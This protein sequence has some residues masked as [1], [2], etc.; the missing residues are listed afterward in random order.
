MDLYQIN[1]VLMVA[2][3]KNFSHAAQEM[4]I[5]TSSLS[6]QIK[7]LEAELRVELFLRTTRS[8]HLTLAEKEF[9]AE[10]LKV[11]SAVDHVHDSMQ[12]YV[13]G[14]SGQ[15][16]LGSLP[17]IKAF[18][19]VNLLGA[20]QKQYPHVDLQL[21]E[22]ECLELYPK[23]QRG[24]IDVAFLS[25]FEKHRAD[26]LSVEG[27]PVFEDEVVMVV[28]KSHPFAGRPYISLREI[29]REKLI[30]PSKNS[31]LYQDITDAC[32]AAG[33]EPRF[34]YSS[35]YVD[36]ALGLVA[37]GL[38]V[39]LFSSCTVLNTLWKNVELVRIQPKIHRVISLVYLKKNK[40]S[41]VV[42]NFI[43]FFQQGGLQGKLPNNVV[44]LVR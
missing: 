40:N 10:A 28:N 17:A 39:T 25:A 35:Q 1:C 3:Y 37:E 8:V 21:Q 38:G 2:K 31:G 4:S 36:T 24:E 6:Q 18:G 14:E 15:I 32:R 34:S 43:K 42:A 5:T 23:L 29:A 16:F 20:F 33:F 11:V 30:A 27:F 19:I 9:I 22:A 41:P 44:E 13:Q 26:K 7:K 12:K